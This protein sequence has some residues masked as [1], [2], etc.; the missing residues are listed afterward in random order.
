[1]GIVNSALGVTVLQ[2]PRQHA[3]SLQST[4]AD[5]IDLSIVP[6][7]AIMMMMMIALFRN[8]NG[9][10]FLIPR[11]RR[12]GDSVVNSELVTID[13]DRFKMGHVELMTIKVLGLATEKISALA[14]S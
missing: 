2:L 8:P 1:M 3:N 9:I 14:A 13:S 11:H 5:L 10:W 6:M 7:S 4:D 12:A